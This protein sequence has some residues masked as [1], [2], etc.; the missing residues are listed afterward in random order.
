MIYT[1]L[2]CRDFTERVASKNSI[3]GGGSVAAL[4][5]AFGSALSSMVAELTV[6]KKKYADV[7]WE[8]QKYM[9]EIK[10]IQE[11]LLTLSQKDTEAFE[12]LSKLYGRKSKDPVEQAQIAKAK[13]DALYECC[14]VPMEII[15]KC[16]RAIEIAKVFSEKANRV[17]IA[18][19][20]SSAVLCKAAMETASFSVYINTNMMKDRERAEKIN[21]KCA[22]LL[23]YYGAYAD[24]VLGHSTYQLI[25]T[26][27]KEEV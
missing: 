21:G 2:S 26:V 17:V 5:G 6:N 11:D 19:A 16:G 20:A 22:S 8:M 13:E 12:P 3:P 15:R 9:A 27:I 24:A 10:M 4:V 18:D 25:N 7:Q 23:V 14:K 1:D